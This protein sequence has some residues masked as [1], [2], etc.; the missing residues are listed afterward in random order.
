[1]G[2][3]VRVKV[4][5][6]DLKRQRIGLSMKLGYLPWRSGPAV[7]GGAVTPGGSGRERQLSLEEQVQMLREKFK[8]L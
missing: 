1:M 3:V 6:V 2:D 7:P 4:I 8:R 5:E